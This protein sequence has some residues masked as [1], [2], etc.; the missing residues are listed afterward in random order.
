[1]K[2]FKIE[3]WIVAVL[4][5]LMS[6]ITFA[7]ILSRYLFHFSFA[8]TEEITINL[9]VWMSVIGAGIA[10]SRGAHL[11]MVTLFDLFPTRMKKAVIVLSA[12]LSAALFLLVSL[13]LVQTIYDE[14]VLF[15]ATSGALGIPIWIYYAGVPVFSIFV[16]KGI[17]QDVTAKFKELDK[18]ADQ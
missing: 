7:N 8:A 6:C 12:I 10:F 13:Y 16:F 5:L 17:Y 9:F 2:S 15:H 14:I 3:H 4:L 1:L 18:K 11:G